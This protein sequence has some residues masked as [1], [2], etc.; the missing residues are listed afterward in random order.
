[1]KK[2]YTA[3]P[4]I[5]I[6]ITLQLAAQNVA[7]PVKVAVFAP[8]YIDDVFDGITYTLGKNNLPKNL[9]PGLEFY[10]GVM[11]AADS[12][13]R[14][15]A[16]VEISIYDTKNTN[17]SLPGLF[18]GGELN[19]TGIFIA[20]ITN[21]AELKQFGDE[22]LKRNIPLI[23]ATYP[24]TVGIS[25]NPNF[26]LLNSS[27]RAHV[28]GIYKYLQKNYS[29]NNI[30]MVKRKG[31][32]ED[33]LKTIFSDLNKSAK[34]I[35]LTMDW[36]E[37]SD[38]FPSRQIISK[39]DSNLNN[40]VVVASPSEKFGLQVV[41]TLSAN[42][43]YRTTAVGMPT[44]D[45]IR[46]LDKSDCRYVDVVYSTPFYYDQSNRTASLI[47]KY[48]EKFHSRPS[49]MVYRG[50]ELVYHFSRLLIK[51][52]DKLLKNLSDK[53][54]TAFSEF[55]IQPVKTRNGIDYFENK[56][57]Y[58]IRKQEGKLKSVW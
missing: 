44:W 31:A 15:G 54:F 32:V 16:S 30:L 50:Y 55:D 36:I 5:L 46:D 43:A 23:S 45:G 10:N 57:L 17:V 18:N 49:D 13:S 4:I 35:A 2:W 58:F 26:V 9:L 11:M 33:N 40:V 27:I 51:H 6:F 29:T 20:A 34:G 28:E 1:M 22:A 14:E 56:K 53:E 42:K 24:N 37:L 8:L 39:L 3:T 12:L 19:N 7:R 41:R 47:K 52:N 48:R 21:A 38:S 25:N